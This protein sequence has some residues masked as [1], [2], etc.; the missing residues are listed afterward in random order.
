MRPRNTLL[1]LLVLLALGGYLYWVELPGQKREAE[2]KKFVGL[3][4]DAVTAIALDYPD[5]SVIHLNPILNRFD[6]GFPERNRAGCDIYDPWRR[7]PLEG[8]C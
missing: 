2:A 1:L 5:R 3:E 8:G 4:K 7:S 6:V